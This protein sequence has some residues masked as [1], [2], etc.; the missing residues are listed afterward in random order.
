[1]SEYRIMKIEN[2]LN[3]SR[4]EEEAPNNFAILDT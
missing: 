3:S 2:Q 4:G 1:M